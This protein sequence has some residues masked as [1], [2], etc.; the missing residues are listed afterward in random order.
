MKFTK[1]YH[2]RNRKQKARQKAIANLPYS[3]TVYNV[4]SMESVE[5]KRFSTYKSAQEY[6]QGSKKAP[7]D[8]YIDC[9]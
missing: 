2:A 9:L 4:N 8:A 7:L 3:V 5:V 1:S 6:A